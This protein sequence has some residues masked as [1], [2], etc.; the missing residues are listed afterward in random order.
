[1]LGFSERGRALLAEM[2]NEETAS[3]PVIIN[4]NKSAKDLNE[5][6]ANLLQLDVHASDVYNLMTAGEI[7]PLSDY[8]HTPV[9]IKK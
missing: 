4:I 6:A 8:R 1:M 7:W 2:R 9:I 3:L 5:K